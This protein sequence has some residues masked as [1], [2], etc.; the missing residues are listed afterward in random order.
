MGFCLELLCQRHTWQ[1]KTMEHLQR[2]H[3]ESHS[4]TAMWHLI[5]V[6]CDRL[7]I[8]VYCFRA[9]RMNFVG[10][11]LFLCWFKFWCTY[12][13]WPWRPIYHTL[14][15]SVCCK[16][17]SPSLRWQSVSLFIFRGEGDNTGK[18]REIEQGSYPAPGV[19]S[20]AS[21]RR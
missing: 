4:F 11:T 18:G 2:N 1:V 7:L 12:V 14:W 10:K 5:T 16:T 8:A 21:G 9:D 19:S 17:L 3:K 6:F 15:Y 13:E 20:F